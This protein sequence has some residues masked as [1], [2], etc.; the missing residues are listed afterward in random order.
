[1]TDED[2]WLDRLLDQAF[3]EINNNTER[4]REL[5]KLFYADHQMIK[6]IAGLVIFIMTYLIGAGIAAHIDFSSGKIGKN[7]N[8]Q[9]Q[10]QTASPVT[11]NTTKGK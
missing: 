5:S 3:T 1:M 4:I 9:V 8:G 10:Q 11:T 2:H 7:S 6:I